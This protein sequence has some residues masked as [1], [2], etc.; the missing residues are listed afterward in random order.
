MTAPRSIASAPTLRLLAGAAALLLVLAG[1]SASGDDS[2]SS[3]ASTTASD[4]SEPS[5]TT[6][7]A[8][9]PTTTEDRPDPTTGTGGTSDLTIDDLE[10]IL[11]SASDVGSG[12]TARPDDESS[13][14]DTDD[15]PDA[16]ER[17]LEEKCPE[18]ADLT[19]ELDDPAQGERDTGRVYSGPDDLQL[20]VGLK[21]DATSDVQGMVDSVEA[22]DACSVTVTEDGTT[23]SIDFDAR[24]DG[25]RGD[26]GVAIDATIRLE[27]AML[28]KPL[29]L[30]LHMVVFL[31]DDVG[32][33]VGATDGLS[34]A[35]FT[36]VPSDPELLGDV[37]DLMENRV[38]DLVGG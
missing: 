4:R 11:P 29:E 26:G 24:A 34:D 37:A 31:V 25:S 2:V 9:G 1:C 32:V 5:T 16:T 13:G 19:A 28:S 20:Q 18:L 7:E 38:E 21:L 15:D 30:Q 22:M 8:D 27:D 10:A 14:D 3:G 6:T 36:V 35:D 17:A 12:W 23:S 33:F